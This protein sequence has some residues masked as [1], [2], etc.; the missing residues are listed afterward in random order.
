MDKLA[1][2]ALGL[3]S[4][5]AARRIRK[6]YAAERR[7]RFLGVLAVGFVVSMLTL[8]LA[9]VGAL[10]WRAF[11][12][13]EL[14]LDLTP[15]AEQVL[16][17]GTQAASGISANLAAFDRLVSDAL[18]D[19]LDDEGEGQG[20]R[21]GSR[22][23]TRLAVAPLAEAVADDP[24]RL[25]QTQRYRVTLSDDLDLYLKGQITD[26]TLLPWP[27][28]VAFTR[29]EPSMEMPTYRAQVDAST[30]AQLRARLA[31]TTGSAPSILAEQGGAIL[32]V[33]NMSSSAMEAVLLTGQP[34]ADAGPGRFRIFWTPESQRAASDADIAA[35]L[36]LKQAGYIRQTFNSRLFTASDSTYPE[37]AGT[38]AA[39]VGS[40][41]TIFVMALFA[42][43]IGV[44]AAIYME[45]FA[46]RNRLTTFIEV[47]INNL[48]AVPS[49]VFG[50]LG[51]AVLLNL[52]GL[53]R[54]A[55]LVGGM[56]LALLTLPGIIIASRAA[57]GT[58][59]EDIRIAAFSLGAS[60]MQVVAHHV[61]PI[62]AP[63]ILTGIIISI[64]RAL[65]ETAPLLLIGMVAFI[66]TVPA[67]LQDE[68]TTLPVLIYK[69]STGAERAWE[70][71]TAATIVILLLI[72][73]LINSVAVYLRQRFERS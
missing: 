66:G 57:L 16:P 62:A 15:T 38:L 34:D 31:A 33:T 54:S 8:L 12:H 43:P 49:I 71:L 20:N 25:G 39:L 37:L 28:P 14:V 65:G 27:E 60:R 53:P 21:L 30:I 5:A 36:A 69:W 32:K 56:V 52:F 35:V 17:A 61:L 18:M 59:P 44:M 29:V 50:L 72:M 13:H 55:P 42:I 63:G 19:A 48:A 46:P 41:L 26:E 7:F 40:L 58:V 23:Y 64:A 70:P 10:S 68:A 22:L 1:E 3:K 11:F 9:S 51:A 2:H 47:N 6:R 67:G 73:V 45:E 24:S 4:D